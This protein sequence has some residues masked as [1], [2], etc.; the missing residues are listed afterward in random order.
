M[1]KKIAIAFESE[2]I[3]ISINDILFTKNIKNQ[4]KKSRK[5]IQ[6]STSIREVG[7]IEPPVVTN[8][9][10]GIKKYLLLDGHLRIEA[11]RDSGARKV[12][13]LVATE[14]EAYTYNK[15]INRLATVQEHKM[16]LKAIDS[17][18]PQERIA[19]VLDV[20]IATIRQKRSLLDGICSEVV[21]LLKDRHC[22]GNSFRTLKLMKPIRQIEVVELMIAMNNFSG[23]YS[24]ALLAATP[25]YQLAQPEK[26]KNFKGISG[27]QI[28]QMESEMAKLQQQIK[29]IG[30]SYGTD[31]LNLVLSRGYVVSLLK[32]NEISNYLEQH[33]NGILSEFKRIS[34]AVSFGQ[35]EM[36]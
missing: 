2:C 33:H 8:K 29:L 17:G 28:A 3:T 36:V 10:D 22:P 27:Q 25:Q 5:Y 1:A 7:I 23:S 6:I 9:V 31:H 14:D 16:I 4:I 24:K 13:C 18:V 12:T 34:E 32:N 35:D 30:D 21:E 20:N 26:L 11:L 15:R 19:K